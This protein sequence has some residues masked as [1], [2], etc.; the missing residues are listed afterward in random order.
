MS[1]FPSNPGRD[2]SNPHSLM[3]RGALTGPLCQGFNEKGQKT[4]RLWLPRTAKQAATMYVDCDILCK[5]IRTCHQRSGTVECA[6]AILDGS[7]TDVLREK[8]GMESF[9][10]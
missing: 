9:T 7:F 4:L 8:K 10:Y 6:K 2:D 3:L 1:S 5:V